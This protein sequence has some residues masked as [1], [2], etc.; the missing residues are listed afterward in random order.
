MSYDQAMSRYRTIA[1]E[2]EAIQWR[3]DNAVFPE[4]WPQWIT[5]AVSLHP[6]ET[7][8]L[9]EINDQWYISASDGEYKVAYG[10]WIVRLDG[11]P[12]PFK[13]DIFVLIYEPSGSIPSTTDNNPENDVSPDPTLSA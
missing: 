8:A 7:G 1:L 3:L 12:Y 4:D 9:F 5:D 13:P 10:D 6:S 11:Q 2:V